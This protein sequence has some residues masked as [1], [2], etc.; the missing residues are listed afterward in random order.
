LAK[1]GRELEARVYDVPTEI[2]QGVA[3]LKLQTMG[4]AIDRLSDEQARYLKSW[5]EGT[6]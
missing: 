4:M 3:E 1:R 2:D 6:Q 5:K